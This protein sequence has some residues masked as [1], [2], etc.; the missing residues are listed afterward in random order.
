MV[1]FL[2]TYPERLLDMHQLMML[3]GTVWLFRSEKTKSKTTNNV[4]TLYSTPAVVSKYFFK[5]FMIK[6]LVT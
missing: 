1:L 4:I 2:C 6:K 5:I 3:K